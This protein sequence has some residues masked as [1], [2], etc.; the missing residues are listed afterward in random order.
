MKTIFS[1]TIILLIFLTNTIAD[2]G[3]VFRV[4]ANKGVNKIKTSTGDI[5]ALKTGS[6]LN[7]GDA[8]IASNGAYI[9]LMH[10]SGRTI[11]IRKAGTFK[12]SDLEKKISTTSSIASRYAQFIMSKM[13]QKDENISKKNYRKNLKSTGAVERATNSNSIK[14]ML[15]GSISNILNPNVII[16]WAGE[17]TNY[18][19][20]VKNIFDDEIFS[21]ETTDTS[22]KI[23]FDDA[24]LVNETVI[25]FEVKSK[26]NDEIKSSIYGIKRISADN[27]KT[28]NENLEMLKAE[29]SDDSSLN[30]LIYA[31]FF[32]ENN[33]LLDALTKYEEAIALSPDVEDFEIMYKK[34]LINNGLSN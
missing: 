17:E 26:D 27:A 34:F 11:E 25:T 14:V 1:I 12:V 2:K 10:K 6:K 31:S 21:T 8:I 33:L 9:G 24:N 16:R 30:K 23:N 19:V 28:I 29:I 18:I 7:A 4:L 3:Y 5:K 15:P 20:S 32:E 13:N 22:I